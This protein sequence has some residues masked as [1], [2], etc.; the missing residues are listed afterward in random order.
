LLDIFETVTFVFSPYEDKQS[1]SDIDIV[2]SSILS[3]DPA[4]TTSTIIGERWFLDK[5]KAALK[6]PA[7]EVSS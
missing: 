3:R 6:P 5:A 1:K 7:L 2:P 4:V